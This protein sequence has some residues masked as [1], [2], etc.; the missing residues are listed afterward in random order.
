MTVVHIVL[1]EF[2]PV[3]ELEVVNDVSKP[4]QTLPLIPAVPEIGN[5]PRR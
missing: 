4:A 5:A 2:R 3:I 1:F